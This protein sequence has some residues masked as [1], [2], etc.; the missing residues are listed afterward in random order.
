MPL[1]AASSEEA[2]SSGAALAARSDLGCADARDAV[3]SEFFGAASAVDIGVHHI[4]DVC[5][6]FNPGALERDDS[7]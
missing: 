5:R 6:E 1:D 4:V 7:G 3:T 2:E